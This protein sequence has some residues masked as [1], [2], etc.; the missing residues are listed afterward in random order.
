VNAP[1]ATVRDAVL[2]LL[3][4]MSAPVAT[5]A[6]EDAAAWAGLEVLEQREP[7]PDPR[8]HRGHWVS[9]LLEPPADFTLAMALEVTCMVYARDP[10]GRQTGPLVA[11]ALG[12]GQARGGL[13]SVLT[14][15]LSHG[16]AEITFG[17][18]EARLRRFFGRL[19]EPFLAQRAGKLGHGG[20]LVR[21]ARVRDSLQWI[22]RHLGQT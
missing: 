4:V 16:H 21:L 3:A 2:L 18:G 9:P 19:P 15:N 12:H 7:R 14:L 6:H 13:R 20:D 22:G 10:E 5:R 11:R 17:A 1:N 8:Y